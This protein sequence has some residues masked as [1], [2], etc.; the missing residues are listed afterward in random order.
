MWCLHDQIRQI[1]VM[2][3]NLIEQVHSA[4]QKCRAELT[5]NEMAGGERSLNRDLTIAIEALEVIRKELQGEV[6][7]RPK[8]QRSAMFTRYVIDEGLHMFINPDLRELV[9]N[10]EYLYSRY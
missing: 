1:N 10:I 6:R 4:L 5:R 2:Y 7:Q 8:G 3:A 9:V